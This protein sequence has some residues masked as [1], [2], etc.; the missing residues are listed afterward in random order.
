MSGLGQML[1]G[2]RGLGGRLP[3]R[4]EARV[5]RSAG[6]VLLAGLLGAAGCEDVQLNWEREQPQR[7]PTDSLAGRAEGVDGAASGG[8]HASPTADTGSSRG[9]QDSAMPLVNLYQL[10][11]LS[12]PGPAEAP[13]GF[14]HV[15][16]G[17]ARAKD[18]A[19]V[20]MAGYIPSGPSGTDD[21]YTLVYPTALEQGLAARAA[22]LLDVQAG[23]EANIWHAT[24]ADALVVLREPGAPAS[25]LRAV[26]ERCMQAL[27]ASELSALQK[28]MAAMLAGE[29]YSQRIY[30]F[31]AADRVYA[32]AYDYAEPGSYEQLAAMYARGRAYL[33]DGRYDLARHTCETIIGHCGAYR[34]CEVYARVRDLYTSCERRTRR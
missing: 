1:P 33:Q 11:L 15:R 16:L 32:R 26:A 4:R 23:D 5:V 27:P 19:Q 18:V 29:V 21:R 12:E 30:D 25:G 10:V 7:R 22:T 20:V 14:R 8:P 13:A 28:W 6:L 9:R 3:G 34:D 17:Q 24:M 2:W 31:A